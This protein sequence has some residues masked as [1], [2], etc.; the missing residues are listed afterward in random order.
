MFEGRAGVLYWQEQRSSSDGNRVNMKTAEQAP[1]PS[2]LRRKWLCGRG[3]Q[4]VALVLGSGLWGGWEL[5]GSAGGA[6][7]TC[8]GVGAVCQQAVRSPVGKA[9]QQAGQSLKA[10]G[11]VSRPGV[12]ISPHQAGSPEGSA[13]AWGGS[14]R[15]ISGWVRPQRRRVRERKG[16][17]DS[18]RTQAWALTSG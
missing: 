12:R 15:P 3:R 13:E 18:G 6:V 5:T 7:G 9:A 14:R 17:Q 8:V 1:Q 11:S 16:C 4:P 2:P 10:S